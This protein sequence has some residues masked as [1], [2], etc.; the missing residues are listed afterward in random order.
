MRSHMFRAAANRGPA[1]FG[2]PIVGA[3]YY[4]I[5]TAI[6]PVVPDNVPAGWPLIAV[7]GQKP[8]TAN[9]G[10]ITIASWTTITGFDAIGG[11]YGTTLG[12]DTGNTRIAAKRT[13]ST[14]SGS[15]TSAGSFKTIS[16]TD[17]NVA[18]GAIVAV[19][20]IGREPGT[21]WAVQ[22]GTV[23]V[24]AAPNPNLSAILPAMTIAAGDVLVWA[25]C[26]PTDVSVPTQFSGHSISASGCTFSTPVELAEV[27]SALGNDIGGFLVWSKCLSS[28]GGSVAATV[29][30]TVGGTKTN[31]RGPISLARVYFT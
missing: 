28:G 1:L 6:Q 10:G 25:M 2:A 7:V 9:G 26:I 21:T 16:L 4:G 23:D 13:T 31:V 29:G 17:S 18:W 24:T 22:G 11:G 8:A 27:Y 15:G 19:P 20:I 30:A 5:D 14:A 12:V 3:A